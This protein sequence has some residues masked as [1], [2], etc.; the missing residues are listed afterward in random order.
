M[1]RANLWIAMAAAVSLLVFIWLFRENDRGD[2]VAK[3]IT[4]AQ[5]RTLAASVPGADPVR[6]AVE[7][8]AVQ[9]KPGDLVSAGSGLRRRALASLVYRIDVPG[10]G[11]VVIDSGMSQ[12]AAEQAGVGVFY[13]DK[14]RKADAVLR[15]ASDVVFTDLDPWHLS[16]LEALATQ[17]N[18]SDGS[19]AGHDGDAVQARLGQLLREATDPALQAQ[20]RPRAISR[21]IVAI[22][23]PTTS[24]SSQLVFVHL[25][26]GREYLFA[27]D[28]SPLADNWMHL[29]ASSQLRYLTGDP[30][31][32]DEVYDWLATIRKLKSE[33]PGLVVVPGDD[34]D[35]LKRK[36]SRTGLVF[37]F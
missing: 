27:G 8:T 31:D 37:G 26:D 2:A 34:V 35:W 25:A 4:M 19:D 24:D 18:P 28:I 22:P 3:P 20:S 17:P 11:P 12:A 13:A 6:I 14:R 21:G 10:S 16:G 36:D 32:R 23:A 1:S 33:A 7:V 15:Q 30:G 5:L 9:N 29:R